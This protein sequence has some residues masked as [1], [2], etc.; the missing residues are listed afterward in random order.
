MG[1]GNSNSLE[2]IGLASPTGKKFPQFRGSL[3]GS[4]ANLPSAS[5]SMD[6]PVTPVPAKHLLSALPEVFALVFLRVFWIT[7]SFPHALEILSGLPAVSHSCS[8]ICCFT[9]HHNNRLLSPTA[10]GSVEILRSSHTVALNLW[11]VIP[12]WSNDPF[13]EVT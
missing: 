8:L 11:V 4:W 10:R 1:L 9:S 13:V 2:Q 7:L 6:C 12:L 5:L 3:L